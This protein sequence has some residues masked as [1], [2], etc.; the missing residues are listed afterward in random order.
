M[1]NTTL[2]TDGQN[3]S[4]S[5][6]DGQES[7]QN[8]SQDADEP[9]LPNFSTP[10]RS[11]SKDDES[12]AG[13]F[14]TG[15]SSIIEGQAEGALPSCWNGDTKSAHMYHAVDIAS[16]LEVDPKYGYLKICAVPQ[17]NDQNLGKDYQQKKL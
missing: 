4:Q 15:D 9:P 13:R 14:S 5:Q 11:I 16:F 3:A 12:H 2:Q 1:V 17:T 10:A 6:V 8:C 7:G